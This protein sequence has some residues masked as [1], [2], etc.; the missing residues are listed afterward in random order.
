MGGDKAKVL[1][2]NR[3]EI[4]RRVTRACRDLGLEPVMVYTQP[5]ALSMHVLDA[6]T[7]VCLGDSTREYTNAAKLIEIAKEQG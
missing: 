3:G 4:A 5:D 2:A 1:I 6:D 7:K